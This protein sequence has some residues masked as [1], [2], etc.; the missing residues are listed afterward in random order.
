MN[1][2]VL[3]FTILGRVA[4]VRA[5]LNPGPGIFHFDVTVMLIPTYSIIVIPF[6]KFIFR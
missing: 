2:L 1:F 6:I 5:I 3:F 4:G